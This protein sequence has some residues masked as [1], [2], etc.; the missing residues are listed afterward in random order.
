MEV[1]REGELGLAQRTLI[2]VILDK[3]SFAASRTSSESRHKCKFGRVLQR[4]ASERRPHAF[5][6][7]LGRAVARRVVR[8]LQNV[9]SGTESNLT[10]REDRSPARAGD[11][12]GAARCNDELLVEVNNVGRPATLAGYVR[13]NIT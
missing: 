8:H 6:T 12:L 2:P 1:P 7:V 10:S 9:S 4:G 13:P 11:V 5:P 3:V